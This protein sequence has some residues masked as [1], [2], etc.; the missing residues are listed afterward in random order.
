M[1][2]TSGP[3]AFPPRI[4]TSTSAAP[5]VLP[6]N[7]TATQ[8]DQGAN[9]TATPNVVPDIIAKMAFDTKFGNLPFHVDMAG[10]YRDFR[11]NTFVPATGINADSSATG[12]GGSFNMNISLAPNFQLIENAFA[13]KGGGRY[14]STGLGP[15][16][17]VTP[18]DAGG[19]DDIALVYSYADILGFEWDAVPAT[20]IYGYYGS[21]HF[22]SRYMQQAN[23]SYVGYGY[24]GSANTN[25]K[26]IEEYTLG[27]TSDPLE[28]PDGG[29][30]EVPRP[31]F[32]PRPRPVVRCRRNTIQRPHQHVL[33]RPPLRPALSRREVVYALCRRPG[34][35]G[36]FP[37]GT[38]LTQNSQFP[39][40]I[41]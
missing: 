2:P 26:L 3:S 35:A 33:R 40:V 9:G 21:T 8:V 16:F 27:L 36:T 11:V 18:P 22:G 34:G 23:G 39:A 7:F 12:Y 25:N 1:R 10:L 6:S 20:K 31:V 29:G 24:A 5:S 14:I 19:V 37:P 38:G 32:L 17:V 28:E 13:S 30:P 41:N 4:L 15:D